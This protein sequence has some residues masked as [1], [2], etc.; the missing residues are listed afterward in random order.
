[1]LNRIASD[2]ILEFVDTVFSTRTG[3]PF[4]ET[5]LKEL[6]VEGET[7]YGH[8]IPPGYKDGKKDGSDDP[9]R[10][11]GDLIV[12]KQILAKGKETSKPVIFI[13][14]DKKEDWWLEQSGR[15]I[16]PRPELREEFIREASNE[17]WMYSVDKFIQ[18]A[19][20]ISNTPVS[21]AV[22]DE[23]VAVSQDARAEVSEEEVIAPQPRNKILHPVLSE[24][25]IFNEIVEFLNSHPSD[26]GSVGLRYFVVNYLGRQNYEINHSYAHINSLAENGR[27]EL[28][29]KENNGIISM[30]IRLPLNG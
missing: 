3:N 5:K 10:K 14:D 25:E 15:T 23:I 1:M 27:I 18:E 24:E 28:F 11:F 22:I 9:Y 6:A 16:G 20:R 17:F 8:D 19:A 7:R 30:R 4:D 12:W 21:K 2:E 13:S 26:D 29:Q